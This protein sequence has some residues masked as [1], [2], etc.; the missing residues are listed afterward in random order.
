[1]GSAHRHAI[2]HD[3]THG[4]HGHVAKHRGCHSRRECGSNDRTSPGERRLTRA[5]GWPQA[6]DTL[7]R[8][9]F[10]PAHRASSAIVASDPSL[11]FHRKPLRASAVRRWPGIRVRTAVTPI[12]ARSTVVSQAPTVNGALGELLAAERSRAERLL[13]GLRVVILALLC[14]AALAYAPAIPPALRVANGAVLAPALTW[15]V[16]EIAIVRRRGGRY[17]AWLSAASPLV[18]VTAITVVVICY[19]L[20]GAPAMALR[21]PIVLVYFVIL[22]ARPITGSARGAALTAAVITLEYAAAVWVLTTSSR[23]GPIVDPI[24]AAGSGR[25][26]LLDEITKVVLLAV[27]G[28]VATYATRW[29][30]GVL[31][32]ALSVQVARDAE[33][34]ELDAR[35][36]DA[37]KLAALGTLAASIAHEVNNPLAAIALSADMLADT[38][39]DACAREEVTAIATD[40]RKTAGVVRDLLSFARAGGQVRA[41]VALDQVMDRA[42][43]KLRPML[44]DTGVVFEVK[45]A[46]DL[47]LVSGDAG[48]LERVLVNLVINSAQAM[49]GQTS[50]R[51]VLVTGVALGASVRLVVEDTGPGFPPGVAPRVFERFFTT[52]PAGKGTGLGLWMVAT[53]VAVHGGEIAAD[54]GERGARFTITLPALRD[55]AAA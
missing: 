44:R 1:M 37:D 38:L 32:R 48:A 45:I 14:G 50:E 28:A 2:G 52:K 26:S 7:I 25:V 15:A 17:P 36:Q 3:S 13:A 55:E 11:P 47:P 29:H 33:Q 53:I 54:N 51:R 9:S 22:A 4:S 49:D 42:L 10:I 20:L 41:A 34:R 46:T 43:A 24:T 19:G 16:L 12:L 18:D 35:L 40:A 8:E 30:E 31:R 6:A 21:A 39:D 23:A 5:Q 27:A